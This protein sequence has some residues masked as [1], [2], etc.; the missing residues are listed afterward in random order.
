MNRINIIGEK[1]LFKIEREIN[2]YECYRQIII[3]RYIYQPHINM[4][5]LTI[6]LIRLEDDIIVCRYFTKI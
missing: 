5:E 3:L 4:I 1:I 6:S 2:L